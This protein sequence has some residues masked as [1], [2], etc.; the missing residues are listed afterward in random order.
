MYSPEI[1][2]R[3]LAQA[4]QAG[5]KFNPLPRDKSTEISTK[6]EA[7]RRNAKGELIPGGGLVRELDG[8]ER[9]FIASE[10]ILCRADFEY[11]AA[12]YHTIKRDP[13][14]G[15]E[16]GVGLTTFLESQKRVLTLLGR[17][18]DVCHAEMK[19]YQ[20]TSGI[21]CYIHKVRQVAVTDLM[22]RISLHRMLFWPGT[23]SFAASTTDDN[24]GEMYE[25]DK[26]AIDNLPF[27]LMPSV[28][29]DVKNT[30][31]GFEHP[32]NSALRYQ[33]ENEK[34]GIGTG[35]Q[36][37]VS[38]LTE[39]PLWKY[40]PRVRYSFFPSL[41]KAIS[42]FHCQEG[43]SAGSGDY[44]EEVTEGC[45]NREVGYEDWTYIFLPWYQNKLKYRKNAPDSWTP[46]E[47]TLKHVELIERT[48]PEFNDGVTAHPT[49]DQLFW[50]ETERAVH[51]KNGETNSFY[52]NYPATPEQSRVNW[53]EGALPVELLEEMEFDIRQPK[54][55]EVQ[56]AI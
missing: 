6:L 11:Y 46:N 33:A 8:R 43:T 28:Y 47:H 19:K 39:V 49:R 50:W 56:V 55:Y 52:A 48:S 36:Q 7:L 40:W 42:T 27:W 26:L 1:V 51:A 45:R 16:A 9:E 14:V 18:E 5:L 37:D 13:G 20:H 34:V 25:R 24:V 21:L 41:P 3:R 35:T 10:R 22:R 32:L 53:S 23:R 38:H 17:R 29:P 12:R 4:R 44:W 54:I 15:T 30:Q 31:L 2:Q